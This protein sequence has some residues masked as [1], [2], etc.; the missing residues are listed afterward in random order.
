MCQNSPA[1]QMFD[2]PANA[3]IDDKD[4]VE[5]PNPDDRVSQHDYDNLIQKNNEFYEDV[6]DGD[7]M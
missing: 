1:V 5:E 2:I 3:L 7:V 4:R 6:K